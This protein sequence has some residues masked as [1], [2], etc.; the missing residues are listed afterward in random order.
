MG[1]QT[2]NS[3]MLKHSYNKKEKTNKITKMAFK[4]SNV[5]VCELPES[6][7]SSALG[8]TSAVD[9]TRARSQWRQYVSSLE[10]L[11]YK[12]TILPADE[13]FP[14]CVFVE[15]TAVIVQ[16]HA[17]LTQPGDPSRRDEINNMRPVLEKQGLVVMKVTDPGVK[18][19]GG[20][21]IFTGKEI[22]VGLSSRTNQE[23]V[24]AIAEAFPGFP[25]TGIP[26]SGPLH[27]K[28]LITLCSPDTFAVSTQS[29]HS[30]TMYQRI[31]KLAKFQYKCIEVPDDMASN[32]IYM[33]GAL[34]H[35][36]WTESKEAAEIFCNYC[37]KTRPGDGPTKSIDLDLS[38]I[39]KA[40]GSLTCMSLRFNPNAAVA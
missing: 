20:D 34:L 2:T 16:G 1:I 12:V 26:V 3:L 14:D 7:S 21:V 29:G 27:H 28:T 38:E 11:G 30:V 15:D 24:D 9:M 19:D 40:V 13:K 35:K 4:F 5:I 17:L 8:L 25:V 18:L 31:Q 10:G 33:N 36:S 39:E 32:V 22:L 23:G 37:S 6:Y